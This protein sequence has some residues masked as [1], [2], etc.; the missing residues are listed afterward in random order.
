M[1]YVYMGQVPE[2]KLMMMMMMM[3]I[4]VLK[5]YNLGYSSQK[6]GFQLFKKSI[7]IVQKS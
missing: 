1:F 3:M 4:F 5:F 7:F 2:M 6:Y